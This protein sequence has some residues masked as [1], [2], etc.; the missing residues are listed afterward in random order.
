MYS[1]NDILDNVKQFNNILSEQQM[2]NTIDVIKNK[3]VNRPDIFSEQKQY[4]INLFENEYFS[5]IIFPI[6][7]DKFE[8][9]GILNDVYCKIQSH[10]DNEEYKILSD[11]KKSMIFSLDINV[12]L[13]HN[14]N[15][16]E[17][18][19]L[20]ILKIDARTCN[21]DEISRV[22][23]LNNDELYTELDKR[24]VSKD[25]RNVS[26]DNLSC[27]KNDS[28]TLPSDFWKNEFLRNF[29][30]EKQNA[31]D[32][33]G[34]LYILPPDNEWTLGYAYEHI[35]NNCIKFPGFYIHK[36]KPYFKFSNYRRI[37]IIFVCTNT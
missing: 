11:D 37:S 13:N 27:N 31:F 34:Y 12:N 6:I 15:L 8:Y 16:N 22:C 25:K 28:L 23:K 21:D 10:T 35:N 32:E 29:Y 3:D 18:L 14:V 30:L 20:S 36:M 24:N 5:N 1:E 17:L 19:G 2:L 33:Q 26:K 7:K 4:C 9:S